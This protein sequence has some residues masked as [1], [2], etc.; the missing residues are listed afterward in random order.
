MSQNVV[1]SFVHDEEENIVMYPLNDPVHAPVAVPGLTKNL[2]SY[3]MA[4]NLHKAP[5]SFSFLDKDP[6]SKNEGIH[7]RM[8]RDEHVHIHLPC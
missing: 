1:I 5:V 3:W 7:V 6:V 2:L 8:P 4:W